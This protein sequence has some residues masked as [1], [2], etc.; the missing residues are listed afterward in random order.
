MLSISVVV[1][2]Y[3]HGDLAVEALRSV[4]PGV[5]VIVVD[6]ASTDD[7]LDVVLAANDDWLVLRNE[8]NRG[9]AASANRGLQ[10][11]TG[12]VR[13]VLNSDARLHPGALGALAAAFEDEQ[14]GI[15]GARL[16]FPDG[17]HQVSAA[18]FPTPGSIVAGSFLLNELY[19]A[20]R[21][22]GRFP[23]ALAMSRKEHDADQYVPWV[24]GTCFAIRDRCLADVVGFDERYPFM[25]EEMDLCL[26][27]RRAGWQIRYCQAAVV[28]HD[29]GASGGEE[30]PRAR[31]Y[32]SGEARFMARAY[33]EGVLTR[34]R[35]ARTVGA[36]LKIV[37]FG[38]AGTVSHRARSR[39][40]W[41]WSALGAVLGHEWRQNVGGDVVVTRW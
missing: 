20:V 12:A 8:Q 22:N 11:C 13:V 35:V 27:A 4:P 1:P 30:G 28:E 6:D 41:Q 38:L 10:A 7:A 24:H 23:L 37:A 21:P 33:G 25:V 18:A 19:R 14:V 34:W 16:V 29:G 3:N 32:I 15:A 31:H 2:I 17:S 5:E 26:R 39:L 40:S 36:V 9:F